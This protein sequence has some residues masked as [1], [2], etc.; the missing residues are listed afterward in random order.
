MNIWYVDIS[1][2]TNLR[3][4]QTVRPNFY[5][6]VRPKWQNFFLQNTELFLYYI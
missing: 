5:P 2:Q 1:D 6:A 3:F 4:G